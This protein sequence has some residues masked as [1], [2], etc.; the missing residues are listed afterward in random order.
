MDS[1]ELFKENFTFR[2][3]GGDKMFFERKRY[4]AWDRFDEKDRELEYW[5]FIND[6]GEELTAST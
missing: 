5:S 6:N 4:I 1:R 3:Q 2:L